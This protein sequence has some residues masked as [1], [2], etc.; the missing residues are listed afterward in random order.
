MKFYSYLPV[1]FQFSKD[2][3]NFT[4]FLTCPWLEFDY[5]WKRNAEL[6]EKQKVEIEGEREGEIIFE[7]ERGREGVLNIVYIPGIQ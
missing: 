5:F 6:I 7:I 2:V 1:I 3:D 4:D